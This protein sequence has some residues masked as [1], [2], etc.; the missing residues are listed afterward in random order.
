MVAPFT[1]FRIYACYEFLPG[2]SPDTINRL[3]VF[4]RFLEL[5]RQTD[6]IFFTR[7]PLSIFFEVAPLTEFRI[8]ACYKFLPVT[9]FRLIRFVVSRFL[10]L[11]RNFFAKQM[12]FFLP[13]ITSHVV[14]P[15]D[16]FDM[17]EVQ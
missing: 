13:A 8:Y 4:E 9:S 15:L 12:V 7:H 16:K 14:A 5:F 11:S 10:S 2:F 1:E 3:K 17:S 6:G